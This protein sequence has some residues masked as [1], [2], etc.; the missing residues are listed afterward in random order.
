MSEPARKL[1]K[2]FFQ[3]HGRGGNH[4][5]SHVPSLP[6]VPL[7]ALGCCSRY[8]LLVI[9]GEGGGADTACILCAGASRQVLPGRTWMPCRATRRAPPVASDVGSRKAS[10][11]EANQ[12]SQ[13]KPGA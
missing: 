2:S 8:R 1:D 5:Q 12:S 10:G 13:Q 6:P 4:D 9:P 7:T 11:L 3:A